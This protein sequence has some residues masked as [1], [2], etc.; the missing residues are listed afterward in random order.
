MKPPKRRSPGAGAVAAGTFLAAAPA[1]ARELGANDRIRIGCIG[2]GGRGWGILH[3]ARQVGEKP[4]INAEI[5]AGCDI[6]EPHRRRMLEAKVPEVYVDYRR[7]MDR[8]DIDGV[9]IATPDHWH[10]PITIAAMESDKDV[11][12]EKPMTRYWHEGKAVYYCGLRTRRVYQIGAGGCSD[13]AWFRARKILEAGGPGQL[14]WSST[15]AFRNS[16]CGQWDYYHID[17]NA[18]PETLDWDR[19]IGSAPKLPFK[20]EYLERFFRWRKYW[21]YSGGIATDLFY[22]AVSHNMIVLGGELPTRVVSDGSIFHHNRDVPDTH[23]CLVEFA[24][25]NI[26]VLP[27]SMVNDT[28]LS[29]AIRGHLGTLY[30]GSLKRESVFS[31]RPAPEPEQKPRPGHMENFLRCMR[32]REEPACSGKAAYATMVIVALTVES[33]RTMKAIRFD[34]VKEEVINPPKPEDYVR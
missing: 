25:G 10:A 9:L 12:C 3:E 17:W 29:E 27:G 15:G 16:T 2:V 8:K 22:H 11:Y 6:Y 20:R 31:E 21:D 13:P 33:Y 32:T 18:T 30:G 5:V 1:L 23:C 19:F 28:G 4:E 7:I 24:S 26:L 14:L 34:P